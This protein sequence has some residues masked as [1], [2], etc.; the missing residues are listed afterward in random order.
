MLKHL[1][2]DD[3]REHVAGD[4]PSRNGNGQYDKREKYR[5]ATETRLPAMP[6][7]ISKGQEK[8]FWTTGNE[9]L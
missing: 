7:P 5:A 3:P 4:A 6:Y 8:R 2:S 9:P 1:V